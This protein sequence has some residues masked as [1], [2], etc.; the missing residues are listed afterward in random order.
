MR[1]VLSD[2]FKNEDIKRD[3]KEVIKPVVSF[4]YD[5][6]Y[7]YIWFICLYNVFF[8]LIVLAILYLLIQMPYRIQRI[9]LEKI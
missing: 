7:V 8:I 4:I 6:I 2:I 1:N 5:E 3:V 9:G